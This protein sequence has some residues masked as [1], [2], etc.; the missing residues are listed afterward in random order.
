VG[1]EASGAGNGHAALVDAYPHTCGDVNPT[2]RRV[3]LRILAPFA[4]AGANRFNCGFHANH[5]TDFLWEY[6]DRLHNLSLFDHHL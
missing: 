5:P 2:P 4:K 3:E 6:Q 1:H